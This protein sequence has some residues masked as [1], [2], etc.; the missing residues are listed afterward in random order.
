M[1]SETSVRQ[2]CR[3]SNVSA[4][5]YEIPMNSMNS[6][7]SVHQNPNVSLGREIPMNSMNSS[8][9]QVHRN[10][11]ELDNISSECAISRTSAV[12]QVHKNSNE[13]DNISSECAISR[14][15]KTSV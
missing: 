2:V 1:N 14:N 15:L 11:N 10:S 5:G 13:L 9:H 12:R 7:T 4:L 8:V 3:N 6:E